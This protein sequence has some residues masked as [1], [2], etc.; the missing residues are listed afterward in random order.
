MSLQDD[1]KTDEDHKDFA[2]SLLLKLVFLYE[3]IKDDLF[4]LSSLFRFLYSISVLHGVPSTAI[5]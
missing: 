3:H 4:S 2:K 1:V 5:A